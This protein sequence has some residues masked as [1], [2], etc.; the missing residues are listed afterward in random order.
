M[1][2]QCAVFVLEMR[3]KNEVR[4]SQSCN[5]CSTECSTQGSI[6]RPSTSILNWFNPTIVSVFPRFFWTER[7]PAGNMRI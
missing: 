2:M 1:K 4:S 7:A 3:I 5:A 6:Q